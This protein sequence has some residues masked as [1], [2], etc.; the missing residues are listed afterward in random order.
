MLVLRGRRKER[1]EI[2][3]YHRETQKQKQLEEVAKETGKT[4]R[5]LILLLFL[6]STTI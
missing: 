6:S 5:K 4:V 3:K 1:G 2:D